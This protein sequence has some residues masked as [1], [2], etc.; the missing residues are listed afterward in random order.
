MEVSESFLNALAE[1]ERCAVE[2]VKSLK[3][4][5]VK[6]RRRVDELE[7]AQASA[8]HHAMPEFSSPQPE[9]EPIIEQQALSSNNSNTDEILGSMVLTP[10]RVDEDAQIIKKILKQKSFKVEEYD[11]TKFYYDGGCFQQIA[12][13]PYFENITL[14]VVVFN[15][16]WMAIDVDFNKNDGAR[17]W[18]I[19][20][21]LF[22]IY[23]TVEL[24]IRFF[25]FSRKRKAFCDHWFAFDLVLV[26]LM[27]TETWVMPLITLISGGEG[28]GLGNAQI[29]RPLRLLKLS[30]LAK[31]MKSMPELM[32]L[33]KGTVVGI[34]SVAITLVLLGAITAVFAIA[35]RTLTDGTEVGEE[36]F[37]SVPFSAYTLVIEGVMPDNG[38]LMTQLGATQWYYALV[39]FLFIFLAA[40]TFMNM[41]IGILCDAVHSVSCDEKEVMNIQNLKDYLE[42]SFFPEDHEDFSHCADNRRV[43]KHMVAEMLDSDSELR[44]IIWECFE[45]LEVD[46]S[47]FS[48]NIVGI[49]ENAP[50]GGMEFD[51]FCNVILKFRATDASM[52]KGIFD[53]RMLVHDHFADVNLRLAHC[54]AAVT[55]LGTPRSTFNMDMSPPRS[56]DEKRRSNDEVAI[57]LER[58]ERML[59]SVTSAQKA[60]HEASKSAGEKGFTI[61]NTINVASARDPYST[62][63]FSSNVVDHQEIKETKSVKGLGHSAANVEDAIPQAGKKSE[64]IPSVT[65]SS[66]TPGQKPLNFAEKP[67]Q[68]ALPQP[69]EVQESFPFL[70]P[71]AQQPKLEEASPNNAQILGKPMVDN[72]FEKYFFF[73]KHISKL[74]FRVE[75]GAGRPAALDIK[76]G[77]V[78]E[79]KGIMSG[80]VLVEMNG[81]ETRG[82]SRDELL[83][84][85]AERPLL[86]KVERHRGI[87]CNV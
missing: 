45:K 57:K 47:S 22:C 81:T 85:L 34:R 14:G 55:N 6:L 53:L 78:A 77:G 15:G 68:R 8:S 1:V 31:M 39:F 26:T 63:G 35:M 82:R 7:K 44:D 74:E 33:I 36:S 65:V 69:R 73:D 16:V 13:S 62:E 42:L 28:G 54:L 75:W 2:E 51:E 17:I 67:V 76:P 23:F 27:I 40:L 87:E 18:M 30:R 37:N 56:P 9:A 11:V 52:I 86:L 59:E 84:I 46:I 19:M 64:F 66:S 3:E 83:P 60:A 48:D 12:R 43:T 71:G 50:E 80:D 72:E 10:H 38:S 58:I 29:L 32:I 79:E 20:N 49:F 25:A 5:N 70:N 24:V 61:Q 21:N 41:L 4:E